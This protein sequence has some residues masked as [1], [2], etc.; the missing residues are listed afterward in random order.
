MH[1]TMLQSNWP[2]KRMTGLD[3]EQMPAL[4][5]SV[6]SLCHFEVRKLCEIP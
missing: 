5:R 3:T 1:V 4:A 6:L 2:D